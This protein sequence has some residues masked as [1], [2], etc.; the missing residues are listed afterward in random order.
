LKPQPTDNSSPDRQKQP[1]TSLSENAFASLLLLLHSI[2]EKQFE[3]AGILIIA[4]AI[5]LFTN[6]LFYGKYVIKFATGTIR[7]Y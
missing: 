1:K 2:P 7:L 5:S 3:S 4:L 6:I